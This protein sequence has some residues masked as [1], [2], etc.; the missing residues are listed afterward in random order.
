M[1]LCIR[2]YGDFSERLRGD[3]LG[4]W[5]HAREQAHL[6]T[7]K[8]EKR[9]REWL[10]G[11]A[12]TKEAVQRLL[13]IRDGV[14]VS[15]QAIAIL[16]DEDRAP[17][18]HVE[19][20]EPVVVSLS[21]R[22]ELAFAG[23]A[24]ASECAGLGVDIERVEPRHPSFVQEWFTAEEQHA[25][26]AAEPLQMHRLVSVF[27]CAKEAALKAARKGL[28]VSAD[29]VLVERVG[30]DGSLDLQC[31]PTLIAGV[32]SAHCWHLPSYVLSWAALPANG[33]R[34]ATPL[35]PHP[36]CLTLP[37]VASEVAVKR[38]KVVG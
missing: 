18:A 6:D 33:G 32:I 7:L 21:H 5:L 19:G 17:V 13:W 38:L 11:R 26:D 9:R 16:P 10:L 25:I 8:V 4:Q 29:R 30:A 22:G 20:H 24:E 15:F 12:V 28:S 37:S 3:R 35:P 36:A 27:W 31:D 34:L 1:I 23:A 14:E 2:S